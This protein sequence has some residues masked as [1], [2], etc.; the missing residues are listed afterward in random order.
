VNPLDIRKRMAGF[1]QKLRSRE[2]LSEDEYAYLEAVFQ[3]LSEGEDPAAVL[4][5]K[6]GRGQ[7]EMDAR[8]RRALHLVIHWMHCAIQPIDAD[9]P[10]HGYSV[11]Q[12]SEEGANILKQL[13]GV[14]NSDAYDASYLRKCY[15]D[16][17]YQ[18]MKKTMVGTF[19]ADSP[20]QP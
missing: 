8:Y 2:E 10:G 3:L 15:Y 12:A 5:L 20:Y 13:L 17:K 1:A 9:L 19:D 4:G 7:S 16:P 6:Y 18:H 14:T 11:T